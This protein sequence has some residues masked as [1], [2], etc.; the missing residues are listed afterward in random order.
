[1]TSPN[2]AP[3]KTLITEAELR[4]ILDAVAHLATTGRIGSVFSDCESRHQAAGAAEAAAECQPAGQ[5]R[6]SIT[7][8]L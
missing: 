8:P 4:D 7:Q 3:A 6:V 5:Q 2:G 1:M